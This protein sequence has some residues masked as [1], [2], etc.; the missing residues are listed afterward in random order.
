MAYRIIEREFADGTY[1][2]I[3]LTDKPRWY[4]KKK[5]WRRCYQE[6]WLCRAFC[7]IDLD[8]FYS[9][10]SAIDWIKE[11]KRCDEKRKEKH[12]KTSYKIVYED[13]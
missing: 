4:S 13:N 11:Q 5:K 3:I 8:H 6:H 12:K 9:L 2:F 7:L 10:Q 1:D